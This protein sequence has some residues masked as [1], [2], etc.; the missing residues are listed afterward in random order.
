MQHAARHDGGAV[1]I[2]HITHLR[3]HGR[4]R[5]VVHGPL[6]EDEPY[7][8][9]TMTRKTDG[10]EWTVAAVERFLVPRRMRPGETIG[11]LL[12][13][14]A[15][16]PDMGDE[17]TFS[18]TNA[19][20]LTFCVPDDL[21]AEAGTLAFTVEGQRAVSVAIPYGAT[22]GQARALIVTAMRDEAGVDVTVDPRA[23]G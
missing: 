21:P 15:E 4:Q 17:V 6:E 18:K 2:A 22:I 3:I 9:W 19:A 7:P 5:V 1:K 16:P 11:I 23:V 20:G 14:Y 8:G 13:L 12:P 10:A